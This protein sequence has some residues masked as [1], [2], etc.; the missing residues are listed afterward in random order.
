[1]YKSSKIHDNAIREFINDATQKKALLVFMVDDFTNVHTK[2]R[3]TDQ[4]TSVASNMAT[5]L[6]KKFNDGSA[7]PVSSNIINPNGI[8][9]NALLDFLMTISVINSRIIDG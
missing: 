2:R 8:S 4:K 7:I 6:L 9:T 1:M 5:I 3:P